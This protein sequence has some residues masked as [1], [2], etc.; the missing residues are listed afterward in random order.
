[1]GFLRELF[2]VQRVHQA[3]HRHEDFGLLARAVDSLRNRHEAKA[4]EPELVGNVRLVCLP[5]RQAACVIDQEHIEL[6]RALG[7]YCKQPL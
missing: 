4:R 5:P 7:N 6:A 3:V 1:M 2:D